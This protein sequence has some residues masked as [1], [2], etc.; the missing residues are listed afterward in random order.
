MTLE[1]NAT[2]TFDLW[3]KYCKYFVQKKVWMCAGDQK[4]KQMLSFLCPKIHLT[5]I[6]CHCWVSSSQIGSILYLLKATNSVNSST[7]PVLQQLRKPNHCTEKKSERKKIH[8]PTIRS[9]KRWGTSH[10]LSFLLVAVAW[11]TAAKQLTWGSIHKVRTCKHQ[12]FNFANVFLGV[13]HS[14]LW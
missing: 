8:L 14:T 1:K 5:E 7:T 12:D 10:G 9:L 3:F 4:K 13:Y 11:S 6:R 2:T